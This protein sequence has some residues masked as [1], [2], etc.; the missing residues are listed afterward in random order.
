[1]IDFEALEARIPGLEVVHEDEYEYYS[2]PISDGTAAEIEEHED[3]TVHVIYRHWDR[4]GGLAKE[5]DTAQ[6]AP[7][8]I[9]G[10]VD[11]VI[12]MSDPEY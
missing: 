10:I 3:G 8:D 2:Y 7:D 4:T 6:F 12:S 5:E 1:M 11:Q 9:D